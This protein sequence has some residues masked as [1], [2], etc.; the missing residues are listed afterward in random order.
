M[1]NEYDFKGRVAI[2]GGYGIGRGIAESLA[3]I[4][5]PSIIGRS[6]SRLT[7]RSRH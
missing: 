7:K 6:R 2:V 5:S 3:C 4:A 1:T